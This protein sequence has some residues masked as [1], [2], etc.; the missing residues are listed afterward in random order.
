MLK[1]HET[2]LTHSGQ[3]FQ[4][5]ARVGLKRIKIQISTQKDIHSLR[6]NVDTN[7]NYIVKK[8][9]LRVSKPLILHLSRTAWKNGKFN[10]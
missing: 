10:L 5:M 2:C 7:K 4:F 6:E 8:M 1:L 3:K 9:G